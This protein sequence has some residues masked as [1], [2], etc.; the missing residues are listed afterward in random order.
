LS[1]PSTLAVIVVVEVTGILIIELPD[2]VPIL[3]VITVFGIVVKL[4]L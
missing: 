1:H 3:E 4:I 2:I